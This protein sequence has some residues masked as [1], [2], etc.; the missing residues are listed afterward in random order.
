MKLKN[1]G[2]K[3]LILGYKD[4]RRGTSYK[5]EHEDQIKNNQQEIYDNIH[6]ILTAFDV[7]SFDNLAIE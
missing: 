1:K 5:K 3:L 2:Y 4:L 6:K 7:V